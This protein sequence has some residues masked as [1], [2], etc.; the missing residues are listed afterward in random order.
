MAASSPGAGT[1]AP[2]A[3]AAL[4]VVGI[5]SAA[6]AVAAFAQAELGLGPVIV[7]GYPGRSG[8]EVPEL[9]D[10]ADGGRLVAL[11]HGTEVRR[12]EVRQLLLLD[13]PSLAGVPGSHRGVIDVTHHGGLLRLDAEIA[14]I[15]HRG[16]Q[17][18]G[19]R[20]V[21]VGMLGLCRHTVRAARQLLAR[22][23]RA[24]RIVIVDP[25]EDPLQDLGRVGGSVLEDL[26]QRGVL[27]IRGIDAVSVGQRAITVD[28]HA[29]IPV[30]LV[31]SGT[32]P[33]AIPGWAGLGPAGLQL[34]GHPGW[35]VISMRGPLPP[36]SHGLVHGPASPDREWLERALHGTHV[37]HRSAVRRSRRW[38]VT[39]DLA[40]VQATRI[41]RHTLQSGRSARLVRGVVSWL[42]RGRPGHAS[43]R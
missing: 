35:G 14:G 16:L 31:A 10:V 15:V 29:T 2:S 40:G 41:G 42:E 7:A 1:H 34:R 5:P 18:A 30:D 28:G 9:Y 24:T 39:T 33:R 11:A 36:A 21:T 4:A 12:V 17:G 8:G 6:H 38:W 43:V 20:V 13:L 26:R 22:H 37:R 23:G 19:Q 27:V 32:W 25:R 3:H